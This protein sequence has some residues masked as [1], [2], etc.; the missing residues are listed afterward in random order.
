MGEIH[1]HT[2]CSR[3]GIDI[4][5]GFIHNLFEQSFRTRYRQIAITNEMKFRDSANDN[6]HLH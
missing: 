5:N 4:E 6:D 1:D 3:E 2:K